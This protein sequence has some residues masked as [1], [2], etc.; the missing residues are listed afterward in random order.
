MTLCEIGAKLGFSYKATRECIAR[1]N[2]DFTGAV[3]GT[4]PFIVCPADWPISGSMNL[5]VK[6]PFSIW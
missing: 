3:Q 4:R 2:T 1:Y 6:N 5:T